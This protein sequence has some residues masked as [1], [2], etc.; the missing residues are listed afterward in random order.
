MA[1]TSMEIAKLAG[2]SR[3]TVD[4]ALHGRGRVSPAMAKKILQIADELGYRPNP[5]GRALALSRKTVRIGIIVQSCETPFM[6]MVLDGVQKA[7]DE[8]QD[9]GAEV[10]LERLESVQVANTLAAIDRLVAQEV[11]AIA[12]TAIE[13]DELRAH[14]NR[15]A[16]T[17]GI[18]FVTFNSDISETKRLCFVG[19]DNIRSGQTCAG[20]MA[21]ALPEGGKVFPLTGHLTNFA[22]KQR[23]SGFL[24]ECQKNFPCIEL[25]PSQPCFDKDRYAYELTVHTLHEHPDLRGIFVAANGQSGVCKALAE[26]DERNKIRLITYD[27]T[28]QNCQHLLEGHIDIVIDQGAFHQGYRPLLLLYDYLV[29]N[30]APDQEFLYT[31]IIIKTKYN[32]SLHP[33]G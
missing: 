14:I 10:L 28:P 25:L 21:L 29:H 30:T 7:V 11:Q 22:H 27:L 20:L 2:V 9:L 8:L 24:D 16:D 12:M 4:R 6:E 3:G 13:H 15:L 32:L 1:V 31:D 23:L 19:L 33:N 5:V 18:P 17:V 26:L